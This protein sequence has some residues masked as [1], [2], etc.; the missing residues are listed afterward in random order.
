[1]PQWIRACATTDVESED[2]I[3]FDHAGATYAIFHAPDG[4][5]MPPMAAAPMRMCIFATGC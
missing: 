3:R 2:L 4:K 5:F 1:M